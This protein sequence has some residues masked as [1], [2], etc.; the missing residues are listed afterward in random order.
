M[1]QLGFNYQGEP[2]VAT[3]DLLPLLQQLLP[4]RALV[5]VLRAKT[6]E[7]QT[8]LLHRQPSPECRDS[9]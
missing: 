3:T 5:L 8:G 6:A 7:S 9:D 2:S 1:W 4:L